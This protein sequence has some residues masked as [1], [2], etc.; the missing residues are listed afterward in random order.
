[1]CHVLDVNDQTNAV[2]TVLFLY[3]SAQLR[4]CLGACK[5]LHIFANYVPRVSF[6]SREKPGDVECYW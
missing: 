4:S 6:K 5:S 3:S 2:R 1:M